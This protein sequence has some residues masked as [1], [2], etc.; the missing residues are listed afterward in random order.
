MIGH[1]TAGFVQRHLAAPGETM[2]PRGKQWPLLQVVPGRSGD[3]DI[4]YRGTSYRR[5]EPYVQRMIS[6]YLGIHT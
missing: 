1:V 2:T 6:I 3:V 4:I 5:G